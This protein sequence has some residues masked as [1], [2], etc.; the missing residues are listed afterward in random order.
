M[1]H[2][3]PKPKSSKTKSERSTLDQPELLVDE[4]ENAP[5]PDSE[6]L[7]D[8]SQPLSESNPLVNEIIE[9]P[10]SPET[11]PLAAR[12]VK[13]TAPPPLPAPGAEH[14]PFLIQTRGL[15]K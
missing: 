1:K 13:K 7:P 3:L 5:A 12:P 14:A 15:V 10:A 9:S 11:P 6:L 8:A 4:T 2:R